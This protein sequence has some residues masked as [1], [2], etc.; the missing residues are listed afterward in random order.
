MKHLLY[1]SLLIFLFT[2]CSK[3][4]PEKDYQVFLDTETSYNQLDEKYAEAEKE[5]KV[6]PEF[7]A[8][9]AAE[10]DSLFEKSKEVYADFMKKHINT[11][12]A[13]DIFSE[14]RWTRRLAADQ[15]DAVLQQVKD[16][17]FMETEVYKNN[18][19]RL[20]I[21]KITVP[22]NTFTDIISK[23]TDGNPIAL[24]DFAG[25]GKYILLDFWASWCP[26]CRAEMP[27]IVALYETY[28]DKNF[29][30]VGYSLDRTEEAWKKGIEDLY[31]TWPQMSDCAF[32]DSPGVKLY[33]VQSIPQLLLINPE[34][35]IVERGFYG[36]ELK[37]ILAKYL[38]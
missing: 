23:D 34:G 11:P 19:E 32:W 12:Y 20:H 18:F 36:D 2:A 26:P 31:I 13:Q 14:S 28:K 35:I 3:P 30:I 1:F 4:S 7:E 27:Q 24:S 29:E 37:E 9:L 17:K 22:G 15:L 5:G 38:D 10:A 8:E 16:S 25:K 21:M 33:A 6:T